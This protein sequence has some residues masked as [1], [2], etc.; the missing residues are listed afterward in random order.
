MNHMSKRH[1]RPFQK[2]NF[3]AFAVLMSLSIGLSSSSVLADD[4]GFGAGA[5]ES[6]SKNAEQTTFPPSNTV[7]HDA[8][9]QA[10]AEQEAS[11][12]AP[13][14]EAPVNTAPSVAPA[15]GAA[16]D[17]SPAPVATPAPVAAP[18]VKAAPVTQTT[19]VNGSAKTIG[20]NGK[21]VMP[22]AKNINNLPRPTIKSGGISPQNENI[23][24]EIFALTDKPRTQESMDQIFSFEKE[25]QAFLDKG[26]NLK[27]LTK[28]Q[29]MYAQCKEVKYGDGEGRALERMA[30]IYLSKGEKTRAKSLIENSMEVLSASQD[31][32]AMGHTRVTA[33]QIYLS[34]DNPLWA[35]RQLEE[36]MKDF[37]S[38]ALTDND[39]AARA[40]LLAAEL[41]VRCDQQKEAVRFYRA[42]A[43]YFGQS[44]NHVMEVNLHNTAASMLQEMGLTT[45]ALEEATKS[46][47]IARATKIDPLTSAA[48][49]QLASAQYG[50][51]E[52]MNARKSL[53]ELLTLKLGPQPALAAAVMTEAYGY[54]LA[55]TGCTDAAKVALDRAYA[56]MKNGA[57]AVHV[58]QVLN[59]LGVLNTLKGNYSVAIEQLRQAADSGSVVGRNRERFPL[60][61]SQNMASALSRSGEN[62]A[63]KGELEGCLRV[64]SKTKTPDQQILAE[65]YGSLGEICLQLKEIPQA[66]AYLKKSIE[67]ASKINCDAVL[68][69]DYVNLAKLQIGM[70]ENPADT[71][72]SAA[73]CFRSPEAGVF[74][75]AESNPFAST[76]DELSSELIS[77]LISHNLIEQAFIT[78]EQVKE[79]GFIN[80]WQKNGG[81]VKPRDRELYNDLVLQRAHLHAAEQTSTPDKTLKQW[82]DWMRRHQVLAADNRELARLISPVPLNLPELVKKAQENTATVLDYCIGPK[83]S[84]VFIIDRAGRLGGTKLAIGRDQLRTQINSMLS[85]SSKSG[86]ENRASEKRLLQALYTELIPEGVARFLPTNPDQLVLF[87]PDSVLF[88]LPFAALVDTH[89]R[90]VIES[91]TLTTLPAVASFLDN[92]V[93][94]GADQALVF[95]AGNESNES[96][97]ALEANELSSLFQPEQVTK[98]IG[99]NADAAQLQE[100][101]KG[102][103]VLHFSAPLLLQ[104]SNLLKSTLPMTVATQGD[105]TEKEKSK[106]ITAEALFKMNLPSDLAVW[107]GTAINPKD[108]Q[109]G[110][111]KVFSRGLAY[112]GVRNVLLSLWV[113]QNPQRTEEL[114][115]FYKARQQG[116]SQAQ[117]LRKAQLLALSKDPSPRSWAAFELIGVGR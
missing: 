96:R 24:K 27:A 102:N 60:V 95:N 22:T 63:A 103:A 3:P 14:T 112:A 26:D 1:L 2:S 45:A 20:K 50:L 6:M 108:S 77:M 18:I 61:I 99:Q 46:V 104:D 51:C 49:T 43:V 101:A 58:A 10:P 113:E 9:G 70:G 75:T 84:F 42:A 76:R 12:S 39:E 25:G 79:E 110:G 37:Q 114:M 36:A 17:T 21:T 30:T 57:P 31:K 53:E 56:G 8:A 29:D 78:A 90:Y 7:Q 62:R 19:V 81:E 73:S 47:T 38:S 4:F 64:M 83:Q 69:R 68:W 72:T 97:E 44:G 86:P 109:G 80:E 16:P 94:Y 92:G 106:K 52:F 34:L 40:M 100:Q 105:G 15:A 41:A 54:A 89:G 115:E 35:L 88:N 33:A 93:S 87:A 32:K 48:L 107:S 5:D 66:D 98:L 23:L 28:F 116:L 11:A 65:V 74:Q 55:A 71:L 13:A 117:S 82:Q 91:H 59:A 111:I 85:L 67:V